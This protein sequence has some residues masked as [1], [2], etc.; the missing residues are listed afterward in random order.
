MTSSE[1]WRVGVLLSQTGVTAAIERSQLNATLLAIE[2]VNATGGILGRAIEPVI[3]DPAS[4]PVQHRRLAERLLTQDRVRL[5]FGCYMSSSR[6]MAIPVVEALRGLLF[7]PTLYEGFEYSPNCIYTGACPNQNSLQLARYLLEVYGNRFLMVGSNYSFPYESNR[8]ITDLVTQSRGKILDEI[9][10]SLDADAE[11][12]RKSIQLIEKLKPDVIFSTVVGQATSTFYRAYREA[13]FDPSV[14]PIASLT[15][16]EAEVAE[17]PPGV[18]EGHITAAPFFE[19]LGTPAATRFVKAF[20]TRFG[21]D[22]PVTACAEAAYSQVHL[23]ARAL[24]RAGTDDPERLILELREAEF[25]APQG[26]VRIDAENNHTYLWPRVARLDSAGRFQIVW[27]PG[28]R[29]KPDPYSVVQ[30]L[31][32]WSADFVHSGHH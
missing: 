12:F 22:A 7:Y 30:S 19:T 2:E 5:I 24:G 4:T 31:D 8:I 27:N 29:V 1:P 13:G 20:K 25:D 14:M 16:S 17:M 3:Y 26:R 10:V 15:T 32:D 23:A 18:A 11:D 6:K 9:Y 21:A 28:M